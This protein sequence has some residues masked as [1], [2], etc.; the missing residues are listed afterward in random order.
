[1]S[2]QPTWIIGAAMTPFGRHKDCDL[3]DL[4]A[5]AARNIHGYRI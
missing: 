5:G 4:G 1:M 3:I 2:N